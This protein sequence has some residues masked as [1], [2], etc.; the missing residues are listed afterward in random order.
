MRFFL[1]LT[2]LLIS[3]YSSSVLHAQEFFFLDDL[4]R[5]FKVQEYTLDTKDIY[6]IKKNINMYNIYISKNNILL[7]S[8]LPDLDE[9]ILPGM[10][11]RGNNWMLIDYDEVREKI[12]S[13]DD[14]QKL[15]DNWGLD[16]TPEKKTLEYK[17]LRKENGMYYVSKQCLTEFFSI[18]ALKSPMV[19][20]YG[21]INTQE[22]KVTIKQMEKSFKKQFPN[23]IF[24]MDVREGILG[25]DLSNSYGFRNYLSKEYSVKGNKAY[26]F[27]TFDGWWAHDGYNEHRGIDRFL[28]IPDKGIVGGSYDFY[29]RLKPKISSDN[30][31]HAPTGLLWH[32]TINEKIMIANELK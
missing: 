19:T 14:L 2:L 8:V 23:Q 4:K 7:L 10:N 21:T 20:T 17:F 18:S 5:D 32:N 15:Y 3:F 28:Y 13:K 25:K 29:F 24:I 9:I 22:N 1:K 31:Y 30:Y 11:E 16:N 6:N 12:F 27:W 26:Q